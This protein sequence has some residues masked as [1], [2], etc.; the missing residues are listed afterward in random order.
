MN[1]S[2]M[3]STLQW[4]RLPEGAEHHV[5]HHDLV[6]AGE[7]GRRP[8]VRA[9]GQAQH[10]S[11]QQGV[12]ITTDLAAGQVPGQELVGHRDHVATPAGQTV[13]ENGKIV[14]LQVRL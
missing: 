6:D 4:T 13:A 5:Q 8:V 1:S 2:E 9:D 11:L 7:G 3:I 10:E 12:D 14:T